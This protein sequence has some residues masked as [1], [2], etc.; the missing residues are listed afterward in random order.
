MSSLQGSV[1]LEANSPFRRPPADAAS[2]PAHWKGAPPAWLRGSVVRTC[3]AVFRTSGWESRH[4]FDALGA[5]FAFR[6]APEPRLDWRLLD[7]E[8]ATLARQG[9]AR[10]ASFG[11][12][13]RRP[14]WRR[15]FQP[16]PRLT[17]N[18]NVAVQA[19]G[20]GLVAMTEAPRQALIDA[21]SLAVTGWVRYDDKLGH[22]AAPTAHP[23][24]DFERRVIVN[25]AQVFGARPECVLYQHPPGEFRRQVLGRWRV[26]ELPYVHSFG[27]TPRQAVL[28]GQPLVVRPRT[29]LWSERPYIDH[30]RWLPERGTRLVVFD[31]AGGEPRIA[32]TDACFVFHVANAYEERDALVVDALAYPDPGIVHELR[33]ERLAQTLAGTPMTK[34]DYVRIRIP[35]TGRATVERRLSPGFEFPAI[36]YRRVAGRRHRF[37]WGADAWLS[38][39]VSALFKLDVESGAARTLRLEDW[40]VGEPL[41]VPA[42]AADAEDA[43]VLLAVGS[44]ATR[45]AAALFVIDAATLDVIASAEAPVSVPLGFH[46]TFLRDAGPQLA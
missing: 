35:P 19:F 8:M 34:P 5:L 31:R 37:C 4:W 14:W 7:C 23:L 41:F 27:L 15:L 2:Y 6:I 21:G 1:D 18:A 16:I 20:P 43:G 17:D 3:P 44:H 40:V 45:D 25:I 32:E 9:L 42:P 36:H 29:M 39:G 30:F 33:T 24:P 10:L 11:T 46:G 38:K 22:E 12:P 13:M 28:I 26:P